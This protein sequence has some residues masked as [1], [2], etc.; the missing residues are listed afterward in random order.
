[1][2]NTN[3]EPM[4]QRILP[5]MGQGNRILGTVALDEETTF[6]GDEVTVLIQGNVYPIQHLA[7][8]RASDREAIHFM[9]IYMDP[10]QE[11]VGIHNHLPDFGSVSDNT[12]LE[13]WR[14]A[15]SMVRSPTYMRNSTWSSFLETRP[16]QDPSVLSVTEVVR[17]SAPT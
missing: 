8:V 12:P 4:V 7:M 6:E 11:R 5:V 13:G 15:Q 10:I 14:N 9:C 2:S 17:V 16:P 3:V 1:M